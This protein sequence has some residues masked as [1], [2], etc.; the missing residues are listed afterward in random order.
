MA[1]VIIFG[2][3][4]FSQLAHFYLTRDSDHEVVGFTLNKEFIAEPSYLGLPV[5]E[6]ES[7]ESSFPP[8][9]Y[10][11]FIPMSPAKVNR[12]RADKYSEAKRKG[13]RCISYISSKATYYDT[14]VGENCF[15][16][17]NNVIQPF[18]K[19]GDNVII[20]S[21]NHIGHHSVVLD[22]CFI[23]SHVVIS[24][25]VTIGEYSFLGVNATIRDGVT[26]ANSNF[27]GAGALIL[28]DTKEFGVYPGIK[29]EMSRVP[30]N[31]LK[32]L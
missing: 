14:P 1:K 29:T 16:F 5:H 4:D 23:S 2:N 20:W 19:I 24:G 21:G 8:D 17:E 6:F 28:E 15:V 11:L 7:L 26:I 12:I 22:H 9:Q 32:G 30:S 10:K 31:R 13:Y 3:K 27:I 25:H 18:S